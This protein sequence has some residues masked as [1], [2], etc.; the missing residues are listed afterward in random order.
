V[1]IADADSPYRNAVEALAPALEDSFEATLQAGPLPLDGM[2]ITRALILRLCAF[3]SSQDRIK[4]ALGK[5]YVGAGADFFVESVLF[6]LRAAIQ[7]HALEDIT[8]EAERAIR[9]KRGAM[10][11]D[12]SVWHDGS[13]IAIIECKTQLGWSRSESWKDRFAEREARLHAEW[14]NAEAFLLVMTNDNWSG[15]GDDPLVGSK[16]FVLSHLRPSLVKPDEV[17]HNVV[18]PIEQLFGRIVALATARRVS[19]LGQAAVG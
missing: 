12:L 18:T 8:A 4:R 19:T 1:S 7:T 9:P 16:Y 15:F 2:E 13:C 5:R 14:P 11:P 3:Y 6:F 17:D 10:R